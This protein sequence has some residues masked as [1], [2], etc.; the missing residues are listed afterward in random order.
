VQTSSSSTAS[1]T[2]SRKVG[3]RFAVIVTGNDTDPQYVQES[4]DADGSSGAGMF[5]RVNGAAIYARGANMIPTEELDGRMNSTALEQT[6]ISARD[7]GFN[8][9]RVWGGGI[10]KP[11]VWYDACDKLGILVYHDLQYAQSGHSP[12]KTATQ[13][14]EYRHQ[15]RR[16]GYHPSIV[17]IDGCNE[18]AVIIGTPTGI[19]A[20]FSLA[21]VAEEDKSRAIWPS[22]P[23][24]GWSHGVN[25]LTGAP[26][27]S[28][29]GLVPAAYESQSQRL[30][31]ASDG[32][33][34]HRFGG[35][36]HME[37][38]GPY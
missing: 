38:H 17:L 34:R 10:F 37:M 1:T 23:S 3:F 11:Q 19:Y 24:A 14:D 15:I 21:I 22:C 32:G 28:P 36:T 8:I 2:A 5:F 12:N 4:K 27:D 31:L 16:L 29:Q 9:M 6:V 13:A 33:S 35:N 30:I 26:N 7:G 18:C 20:S 25:R